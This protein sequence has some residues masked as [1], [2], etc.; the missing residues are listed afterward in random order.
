MINKIILI[1]NLGKDAEARQTQN[2]VRTT[3]TLATSE[4]YRD[5]GGEWQQ[6]TQWH[7][8]VTWGKLAEKCGDF[9]KGQTVFVEGKLTTR[10]YEKDGQ[11]RYI[12]EVVAGYA[13]IIGKNEKDEH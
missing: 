7:N 8:I 6:E 4:S 10:Q 11:T 2:S 12:A 5:K 13:R 1:G 3:F 9:R